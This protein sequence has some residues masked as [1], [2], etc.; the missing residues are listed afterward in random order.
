MRAKSLRRAE[1]KRES[2]KPV[3]GIIAACTREVHPA[4][5]T[6]HDYVR[7]VERA[8]G[9]ALLLPAT[10]DA[11][12]AGMAQWLAL[13]GGFVLPGGGDVAPTYYGQSPIIVRSSSFLEDMYN[14][15]SSG[16]NGDLAMNALSALI[17]ER[18]ALSIRSK[19]LN[20]NFLTI[21]ESTA[22]L[23]KAVMIGICPLGCLGIGIL[24]VLRR[25]RNQNAPV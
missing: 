16:A 9:L 14:A 19:S 5:T 24:V 10:P 8:G 11:V 4:Y 2:M 17:G 13:C 15:Y 12:S 3:I 21:S 20:Y 7:A 25:R 1:G 22:S 6:G 18:E 23:L